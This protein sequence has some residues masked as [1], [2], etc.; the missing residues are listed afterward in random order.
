[1]HQKASKSATC[2]IISFLLIGISCKKS[3]EQEPF[4]LGIGYG[5]HNVALLVKDL[6]ATRNFYRDTLGFNLRGSFDEGL[7]DGSVT[8]STMFPDMSNLEILSLNDSLI[9]PADN[10]FLSSFLE[11]NEGIRFYTLSSSSADS[12][13]MWLT[14]QGFKMDPILP[15]RIDE[16]DKGWSWD[17]GSP[18]RKSLDFNNS[19]PPQSLPRFIERADLDHKRA[20]KEWTTYYNYR[21]MN[22]INPNG[23][24]GMSAIRIAVEDL[25]NAT[26]EYQKMGFKK[27]ESN[28]SMARF[29]LARN[30]ELHLIAPTSKADEISKFLDERGSGVFALRFEVVNLDTTYNY[31]KKRLP[32]EAIDIGGNPVCL[33]VFKAYAYGVQLEFVKEPEEQ[34]AM[35]E[36]LK[37]DDVLDS[38]AAQNAAAMYKKY[39][40]LCHGENREGYAADHAPSLRSHSLLATSEYTNF[41]RYTIQFGRSGTAMGGYISRQGGPL[42]FIEIELLLKWLYEKSGVEEPIKLSREPVVGD[43]QLGAEI[44]KSTCARCHGENGEGITAPALGNSMLLATATDH[45]LRYAIAEG[46]DNTPMKAFKDSLNNKEIDAVTA[47]LRSRAS[48]W[49]VPPKTTIASIPPPEDYI[50]NPNSRV[51]TFTLKEG[52]YLPAKQLIKALEDSLRLVMLDARSEVAWRQMHIP[53]SIPVPYY[54]EPENFVTN[55][56]ND[57]TWIVVYCACP[58]RASDKVVS[59]LRK[60]GFKNTAILDEGILVW[61][62]LGYPVEHGN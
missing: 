13:S 34:S 44:Y 52:K 1:M 39:C 17:D 36:R 45:F 61:G 26:R 5:I 29:K 4:L 58:H 53:G 30:Q 40:A 18:Q 50:L 6:E 60:N 12:T 51:P 38:A 49:D 25:G 14:S 31:L 22:R 33:S 47:F 16:V 21:R 8:I 57:S 41:M 27:L 35:A 15:Y 3:N 32:K 55:I 59:T 20:I 11:N 2:L 19:N 48:G 28:D 46:R 23:V 62:E 56:P 37:Q 42:E 10:S 9:D 7:I 54:E 43:V 24:V